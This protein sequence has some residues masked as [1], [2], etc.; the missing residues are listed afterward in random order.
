MPEGADGRGRQYTNSQANKDLAAVKVPVD[1]NKPAKRSAF[2]IYQERKKALEQRVDLSGN[3]N[4][5][6][7]ADLR[8]GADQGH[9]FIQFQVTD[10]KSGNFVNIN[11]YQPPGFSVA[12]GASYTGFDMGTLK[13]TAGLLNAVRKG[14]G[15]SDADL[16]SLAIIG[17]D[18]QASEGVN[19]ITSAAA[20]ASGIATNPYTRTAYETTN[21]RTFNFSFKLIAESAEESEQARAIERTFRKFLYPKRAGSIALTYPPLFRIRFFAPDTATDAEGGNADGINQYMPNI[22]PSYLTSL[23]STFN[24]TAI[25]VHED[26]NAPMEVDL[27]LSFQEERTLIRQDLY[28]T[29]ND[30]LEFDG[31]F[32]DGDTGTLTT[33]TGDPVG[34]ALNVVGALEGAVADAKD[35]VK[36]GGD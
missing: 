21:V 2:E 34:K 12:D 36:G 27:S 24:A 28:E 25:S 33:G 30:I 35:K 3:Q 9:P 1:V 11:L 17:K 7:P 16:F 8:Q 26:T 31:L 32:K 14:E 4:L 19:K 5:F 10:L 6:F 23:E 18:K 22:K 15:V 20:V 13:G 29:D